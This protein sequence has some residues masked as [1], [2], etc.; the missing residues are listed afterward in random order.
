MKWPGCVCVNFVLKALAPCFSKKKR[1]L[2]RGGLGRRWGGKGGWCVSGVWMFFC[3]RYLI[4]GVGIGV[5]VSPEWS[6]F[7]GWGLSF[8]FFFLTAKVLWAC[9]CSS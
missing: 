8:F 7:S 1:D 2:A 9:W 6:I 3:S 4:S 5:Y